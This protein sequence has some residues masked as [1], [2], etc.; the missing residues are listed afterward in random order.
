MC[1]MVINCVPTPKLRGRMLRGLLGHLRPGGWLFLTLPL[2]CLTHSPTTTWGQFVV[3]LKKVG[4]IPVEWKASPKVAF[5]CLRRQKDAAGGGGG[6]D[7]EE[8]RL[9]VP[10]DVAALAKKTAKTRT[11]AFQVTL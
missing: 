2:R 9:E 11:N 7:V 5:F 6:G 1:S 4:F 8:V 10:E 3:T